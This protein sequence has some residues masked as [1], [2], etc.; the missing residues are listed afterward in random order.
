M[1]FC[2]TLVD[3]SIKIKQAHDLRGPT[4]DL[5]KELGLTDLALFTEAS[6][7]RHLSQADRHTAFGSHPGSFDHFPTGALVPLPGHLRQ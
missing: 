6:Y 7:T 2:L 4:I 5:V 1:A 3:Q